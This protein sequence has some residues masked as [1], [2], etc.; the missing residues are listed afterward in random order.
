[1]APL[2]PERIALQV[3]IAKSTYERLQYAQALLGHQIPSGDVAEVLDRALNAL[4]GQLEK[5]RFAATPRPRPQ[6]SSADPRHIPA[7]V[8]RTVWER[9]GGQCTFMSEAGQRCPARRRLE[10]DHVDPVARGG[11][12]T[13]AGIRIRCRAHNQFTA[14]CTF[15]SGF[16]SDKRAEAQARAEARKQAKARIGRDQ[17]AA[18]RRGPQRGQ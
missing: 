18:P 5:A 14:E 8:K 16:M 4:I 1:V 3:T 10:Y 2:S 9:D 17:M 11:E 15:G 12:A 6:R 13:V 7:H